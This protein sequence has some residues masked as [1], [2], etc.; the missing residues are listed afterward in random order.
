MIDG[1]NDSGAAGKIHFRSKQI[2]EQP[3]FPQNSFG[4]VYSVEFLTLL[5]Q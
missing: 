4:L 3:V 1:H 2:T 5:G